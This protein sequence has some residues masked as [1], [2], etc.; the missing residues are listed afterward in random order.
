M[1]ELTKKPNT[2]DYVNFS[3]R[4]SAK[5]ARKV[6]KILSSL[7]AEDVKD[8]VSWEKVFPNFNSGVALRGARKRENLTQKELADRIGIKQ[9]HVSQMENNKRPIGKEMAKRF[10]KVLYVDYRVFL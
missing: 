10:S 7:G 5:Q 3:F 6:K 9:V 4:I 1:L 2:T 8:S